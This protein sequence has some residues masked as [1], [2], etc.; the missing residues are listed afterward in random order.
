MDYTKFAKLVED[1][2]KTMYQMMALEY[3][4]RFATALTELNEKYDIVLPKEIGMF[5]K[6]VEKSPRST[7][8]DVY[9][10]LDVYIG[11]DPLWRIIL[12]SKRL[13][14]VWQHA[15]FE[16]AEDRIKTMISGLCDVDKSVNQPDLTRTVEKVADY[17]KAA[18]RMAVGNTDMFN[19]PV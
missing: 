14:W 4:G 10:M 7:A 6:L 8:K 12:Q 17:F 16:K 19:G 1:A 11:D 3:A 5:D 9:A 13:H 18:Y 2:F 15:E